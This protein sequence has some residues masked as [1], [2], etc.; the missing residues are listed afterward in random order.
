M[1]ARSRLQQLRAV[2]D[3]AAARRSDI[4]AIEVRRWWSELGV[5]T[6]ELHDMTLAFQRIVH[7]NDALMFVERRLTKTNLTH[8]EVH[9][10]RKLVGPLRKTL[11]NAVEAGRIAVYRG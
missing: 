2:M 4:P 8:R 1:K 11:T 3:L 10:L 6:E 7:A 9:S 5:V